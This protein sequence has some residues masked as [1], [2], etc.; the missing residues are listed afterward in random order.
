MSDMADDPLRDYLA[1]KADYDEVAHQLVQLGQIIYRVGQALMSNPPNLVI[2]QTS[3][4]AS[5]AL[6]HGRT[7]MINSDEWPPVE[8]LISAL[9]D[10]HR[11]NQ[12]AHELYH[13]LPAEVREQVHAPGPRAFK[14]G[15]PP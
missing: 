14:G 5:E 13:A 4:G 10:Y 15:A 7:L 12:R 1:A 3:M 9:R 6:L 8:H 2:S 11:A